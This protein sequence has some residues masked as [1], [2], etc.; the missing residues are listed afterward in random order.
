MKNKKVKVE[1]KEE[2]ELSSSTI[3]LIILGITVLVILVIGFTIGWEKFMPWL[4]SEPSYTITDLK[5]DCHNENNNGYMDCISFGLYQIKNNNF[6]VTEYI[7][8][9]KD[10]FP[11][12]QV[13]EQ[14]E[15]DSIRIKKLRGGIKLNASGI[16]KIELS[17][18]TCEKIKNNTYLCGSYEIQNISS[19]DL[20]KEWLD[21]NCECMEKGK[22][23]CDKGYKI[24]NK[25]II[26]REGIYHETCM[27]EI[28]SFSFKEGLRIYSNLDS[29][30]Y[31]C[32]SYSCINGRYEVSLR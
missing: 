26:D 16:S 29:I 25:S 10:N 4:S 12:K 24:N 31:E 2:F 15:V 17:D 5:A 13:C 27:K 23:F 21:E 18:S 8:S 14:K 30:N 3:I 1:K 22:M 28:Y 19:K 7:K 11:E 6:N 32:S 9:C 20:K